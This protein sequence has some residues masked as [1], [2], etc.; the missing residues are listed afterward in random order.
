LKETSDAVYFAELATLI[1]KLSADWI[2]VYDKCCCQLKPT[3]FSAWI[4]TLREDIPKARPADGCDFIKKVCGVLLQL[5]P[6][7]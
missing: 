5:R 3:W 6:F 7:L 2:D 4:S 1:S